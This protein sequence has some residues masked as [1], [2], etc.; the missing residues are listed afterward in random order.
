MDMRHSLSRFP[1][2]EVFQ[3]K[4]RKRK[5][6]RNSKR[7]LQKLLRN[8]K[9]RIQHRLRKK[10]WDE[11]RRPMFQ[12][13]NI[14]Y[15]L[16][17]KSTGL[18]C[19]GLGAFL[20]LVERLG[21]TR[22][23][24]ANL[25][26]LK[27]H[28]PYFESDHVLNLTYNLLVGGKTIND[29]ELLRTNETYL[30]V[31]G[32]QRI[33]DPTTAGDFLRRFQPADIDALMNVI[34]SKRLAVWKQQPDSFFDQAIIEADGTIVETTGACKEGMDVSYN[35]KWGYHPLLVSLAN[36][37]EPLFLYNRSANRPSYEGAADYF[38]RAA[39]LC[40]QGGFRTILFRGD[41]DFTQAAHLDRW[42]KA[43]FGFVFGIDAQPNLVARAEQ[44]PQRVW[45]TLNRPAC[46]EV[47]TQP[48]KH[49]DQIKEAV[50]QRRG[51]R[52]VRLL[53]E[54]VAEFNYQPGACGQEYLIVVLRKQLVWEQRGQVVEEETRYFFY[55]TNRW[56][57]SC[58]EVVFFANDRCNQENLIEQ[59][60]NGVRGLRAPVNTL[61]A[62]WAYMV[63]GALAW[64][65]KVWLGLLQ[66]KKQGLPS[67]ITMEFKK[68]LDEVMLLPCQIVR[69][70][71]RLIFRLL[72]W[73]P[74][75]DVLCRVREWLPLLGGT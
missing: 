48:R 50:V 31:L 51:Y 19:A 73:N 9:R 59:L 70:G 47:A 38:D 23:L 55:I 20:L 58:A 46:Y 68:F 42:D 66:P 75:V 16:A 41:T 37:Q 7:R 15:D 22:A 44:L 62:N 69:A 25:H 12:K 4:A 13:R 21:L 64:N 27:R 26:L 40:Q 49:P 28:V 10:Q 36:T 57:W 56:T 60:K 6:H 74:W 24:D 45:T 32:A 29:L 3:V 72:Q 71:R 2:I 63:I 53:G 65:L 8:S 67:L 33:P 35:G 39:T 43:G 11:Q 17:D 1:G 14:H 34:N 52:N 5:A 54:Q 61:A 18:R 30:D